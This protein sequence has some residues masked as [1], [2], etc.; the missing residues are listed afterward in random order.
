[1]SKEPLVLTNDVIANVEFRRCKV[2]R[3]E[4]PRLK[5]G[6]LANGNARWVDTNNSPWSGKTCPQCFSDYVNKRRL[7]KRRRNK[8]FRLRDNAKRR[9][10]YARTGR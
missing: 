1:M 4:K 6:V 10:Y 3:E 2:C 5:N 7:A 8:D 9:K